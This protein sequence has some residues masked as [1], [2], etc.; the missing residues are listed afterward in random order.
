MRRNALHGPSIPWMSE[1]GKCPINHVTGQQECN[2]GSDPFGDSPSVC[3]S[4]R[5]TG[6]GDWETEG[7]VEMLEGWAFGGL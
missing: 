1:V 7:G 5:E 3:R 2:G 4:I 6:L